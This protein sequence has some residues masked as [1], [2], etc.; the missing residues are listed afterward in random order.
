M[1]Q[2]ITTFDFGVEQTRLNAL[3]TQIRNLLKITRDDTSPQSEKDQANKT[4][5]EMMSNGTLAVVLNDSYQS[6]NQKAAKVAQE[7]ELNKKALERLAQVFLSVNFINNT[8]FNDN[9]GS[10]DEYNLMTDII[11]FLKTKPSKM[12]ILGELSKLAVNGGKFANILKVFK[13]AK[14]LDKE[15]MVATGI[16]LQNLQNTMHTLGLPPIN[17]AGFLQKTISNEPLKL[18]KK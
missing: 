18:D 10:L 16:V 8:L 5:G 11:D 4:L 13:N 1:T 9:N 15:K 7:L 6:Q 12:R 17:I 14:K 3:N 2:E